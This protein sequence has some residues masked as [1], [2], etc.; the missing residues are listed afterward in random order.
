MTRVEQ[1]ATWEARAMLHVGLMIDRYLA[2]QPPPR[3]SRVAA[4]LADWAARLRADGHAR[5][6]IAAARPLTR[7]EA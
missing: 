2:E 4:D 3:G 1:A 6:N 5:L 7:L